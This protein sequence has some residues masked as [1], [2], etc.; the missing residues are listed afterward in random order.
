MQLLLISPCDLLINVTLTVS[1]INVSFAAAFLIQSS[2]TDNLF[3]LATSSYLVGFILL[4]LKCSITFSMYF[5]GTGLL[6]LLDIMKN[7]SFMP[8]SHLVCHLDLN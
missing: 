4:P 3:W 2:H 7:S 8:V 5:F 6:Y 1:I